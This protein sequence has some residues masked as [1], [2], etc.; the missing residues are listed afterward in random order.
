VPNLA[1]PG[2]GSMMFELFD[3][4]DGGGLTRKKVARRGTWR[5]V[6]R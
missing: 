4:K 3:P 5:K 2:R 6:V 1:I